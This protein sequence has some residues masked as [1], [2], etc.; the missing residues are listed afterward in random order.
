MWKK[1]YQKKNTKNRL[2]KTQPPYRVKTDDRIIQIIIAFICGASGWVQSQNT[3]QEYYLYAEAVYKTTVMSL[4]HICFKS[5]TIF[6]ILFYSFLHKTFFKG[7]TLK[8]SMN[9][10][11]KGLHVLLSLNTTQSESGISQIHKCLPLLDLSF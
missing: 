4:K 3:I 11:Q 7:Q 1:A 5:R 2:T 8:V 6:F 10:G 9:S